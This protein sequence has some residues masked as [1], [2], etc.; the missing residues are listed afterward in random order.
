MVN[1][2][3]VGLSGKFITKL[4]ALQVQNV[5]YFVNVYSNILSFPEIYGK[6]WW[7]I[8]F[9][10][11]F[12][13]IAIRWYQRVMGS[14]Q[15]RAKF[16]W[17]S[18]AFVFDLTFLFVQYY[19]SANSAKA[20]YHLVNYFH[21]RSMQHQQNWDI[22]LLSFMNV[23]TVTFHHYDICYRPFQSSPPYECIPLRKSCRLGKYY[24]ITGLI[25]VSTS[26]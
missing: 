11:E 16:V 21:H 25:L 5:L 23:M 12:I 1:H 2:D 17:H 7:I 9:I 10:A 22:I 4:L 15:T 8:W 19:S 18:F 14:S 26:I 24:Q 6:N 13:V 20:W 3:C